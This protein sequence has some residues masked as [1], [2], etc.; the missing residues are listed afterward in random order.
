MRAAAAIDVLIAAY[1]V[2]NDAVVLNSDQDFGYIE[3]ATAGAVRQEYI[4]E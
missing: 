4:A 2:A 1:A 3:L